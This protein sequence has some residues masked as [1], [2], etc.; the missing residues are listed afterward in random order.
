MNRY[1]TRKLNKSILYPLIGI[2][3]GIVPRIINI[4]IFAMITWGISTCFLMAGLVYW[5]GTILEV[6]K[7][8][9]KW[10]APLFIAGSL[11]NIAIIALNIFNYLQM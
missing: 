4:G 1:A 5:V 3:F 8:E 2:I 11:L 7:G 9:I 6:P 10:N